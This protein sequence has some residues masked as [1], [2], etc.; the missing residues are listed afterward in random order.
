MNIYFRKHQKVGQ[1]LQC[2]S[3]KLGLKKE[4]NPVKTFKTPWLGKKNTDGE[5]AKMTQDK[6]ADAGIEK[7]GA[8]SGGKDWAEKQYIED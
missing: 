8:K 7:W 2:P 1:Q 4:M 5:D 3:L 6:K